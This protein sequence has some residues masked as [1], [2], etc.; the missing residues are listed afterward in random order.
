MNTR[1]H[2][3]VGVIFS[4]DKKQVLISKRKSHQHLAGLWEFPGGKVEKDE[5]VRRA[6]EREL[7][8]ELGI[9]VKEVKQLTTISYDYSDKQVLLDVWQVNGWSGEPESRENQELKWVKVDELSC[10]D[11]PEAN[12]HI[13]QSLLLKPVYLIS[14]KSYENAN[15]FI[16]KIEQC[17]SA[18]I[19][20]FQLRLESKIEPEYSQLIKR[21][22]QLTQNNDVKFI[23]NGKPSDIKK[24]NVDG[25]HIK[26][27]EL[28]N[29]NERPMSEE[30][31]LGASCHNEKELLQAE[32]LNVNYASL[33]PVKKTSSHADSVPLGWDAFQILS[34][35]VTFPVYALGG[36]SFNDLE[37]A[38]SNNAYGIAMISAIWNELENI[39]GHL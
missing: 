2:V 32:K 34:K 20:L 31:I 4:S 1:I 19:K 10:Y 8:E 21:L 36:M 27:K 39:K 33:S 9:K 7:Y 35:K 29:F 3:A 37:I 11:F 13:I 28:F 16:S 22:S 5:D 14:P 15:D 17:F 18:G 23:L 38:K 12:K 30:F 6:L 24:H 26:S 25:I